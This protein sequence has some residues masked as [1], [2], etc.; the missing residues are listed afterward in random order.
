MSPRASSNHLGAEGAGPS[1]KEFVEHVPVTLNDAGDTAGWVSKEVVDRLWLEV[2]GELV[3]QLWV[4]DVAVRAWDAELRSAGVAGVG[5]PE[6]HRMKGYARRLMEACE[7]FAADRGYPISTL[8]GIPDFYHRFGYATVC[9]EFQIRIELDALETDGP[10][11]SLEDLQPSDWVPIARMCNAAYGSLDGSVVRREGAWRGPR[12]GSD[13]FR[14]PQAFV[15]R[16]ARGRPAAYA[17]VDTELTDGCLSVSEAVAGHDAAGLALAGGLA[18]M[19]RSR[20]ATGLLASLHP[21]TGLGPL[22]TRLGGA[23][24]VTRPEDAGY[25][26]CIVD[27]DA[28]LQKC[29]PALAYRAAAC[30][31]P[32]PGTLHV[33]TDIGEGCV[34]LGGQSPPAELSIDRLGLVQLLFGYR[35][36][37]ELQEIG[38]ARATGVSDAVLAKLFPRNDGYCFWPDRY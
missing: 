11:A 28:V 15:S 30:E 14:K 2:D 38:Q 7:R 1:L 20:G 37:G 18:G 35:T 27:L 25:M 26:A 5:T 6:P 29:T 33:K 9:P 36:F 22:L 21:G 23:V 31:L 17:V 34:T 19:A 24:E 4:V 8:F 32:L 3:S 12:Q 13:W 16:D 10:A